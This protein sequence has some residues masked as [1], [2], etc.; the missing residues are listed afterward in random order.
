LNSKRVVVVVAHG[1]VFVYAADEEFDE[2]Y[3]E[4]GIELDDVVRC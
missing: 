1:F 2:L 3:F 4:F